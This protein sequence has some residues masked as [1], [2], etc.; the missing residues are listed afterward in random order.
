MWAE[1]LDTCIC[2]AF[3]NITVRSLGAYHDGDGN[4]CTAKVQNVMSPAAMQLTEATFDN[5]FY[6]SNC[7]V[8]YFRQY[9]SSIPELVA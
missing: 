5:P 7:S 8:T 9:L 4:A 3:Q 1:S 2:F 6:F